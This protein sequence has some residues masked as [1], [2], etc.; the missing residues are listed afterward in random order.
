MAVIKIV[1]L[2]DTVVFY[3]KQIVKMTALLIIMNS[4]LEFGNFVCIQQILHAK[5]EFNF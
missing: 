1:L 2:E 4:D 3:V 5:F